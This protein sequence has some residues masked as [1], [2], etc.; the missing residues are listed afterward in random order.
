MSWSCTSQRI[1]ALSSTEAEW[2]ALSDL[3]KMILWFILLLAQMGCRTTPVEV[4]IDNAAAIKLAG[5]ST[6]FARSKHILV[7]NLHARELAAAEII[8]L[9]KVLGTDNMSDLL[10]KITSHLLSLQRR[11]RRQ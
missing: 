2:I 10:T 8:H 11:Q 9:L 6:F 4:N 5:H 3:C 1:I 7:R